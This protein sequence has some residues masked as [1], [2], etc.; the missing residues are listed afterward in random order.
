M[1]IDLGDHMPAIGFKPHWRVIGKPGCTMLPSTNFSVDRDVVVVIEGDQLTQFQCACKGAGFV[2]NALHQTTV[3]K[4]SIGVVIDNV[5]TVTV[6]LCGQT[7]FGNRHTNSVGNALTQRTGRSLHARCIAVFRMP[8]S[9]GMELPKLFQIIN[10]E[11]VAG[12]V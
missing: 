3:A 4:K 7:L 10:S 9:L 5:V 12:Q 2:R 8:G 11:I 6:E 1:P